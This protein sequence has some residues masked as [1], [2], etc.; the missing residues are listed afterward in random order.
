MTFRQ[1]GIA[2]VLAVGT[3]AAA[4]TPVAGAYTADEQAF[5]SAA[6]SVGYS[7]DQHR[8]ISI[9]LVRNVLI[10]PVIA[11]ALAVPAHADEEQNASFY[12]LLTADEQHPMQGSR[13]AHDR[14]I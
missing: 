10:V 6:A 5:L 1:L 11:T 8:W 13:S 14:V 9:R 2:A 12:R 7:A 4:G 3:I